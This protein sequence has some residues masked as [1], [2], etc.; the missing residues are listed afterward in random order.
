M[1]NNIQKQLDGI[2]HALSDQTRRDIVQRLSQE[3][4]TA[5]E[6]AEKYSMSFPAV[7]KHLR[8]LRQSRLVKGQRLGR[9]HIFSINSQ[10]LNKARAWMQHWSKYWNDRLDNLENFLSTK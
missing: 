8:V 7:S 9:R 5:S 2:F 1:V 10:E 6:L 3:Q 4:H